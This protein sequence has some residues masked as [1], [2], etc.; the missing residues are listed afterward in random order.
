MST[1][2]NIAK[3]KDLI[4]NGETESAIDQLKAYFKDT[5]FENDSHLIS[6]RFH[7]YSKKN[8]RGLISREDADVELRRMNSSIC[9]LFR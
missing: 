5:A 7:A 4:S 8:R 6:G 2:E 1:N 3:I 9:E